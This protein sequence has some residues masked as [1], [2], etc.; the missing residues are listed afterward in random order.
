MHERR[1]M[2]RMRPNIG[3]IVASPSDHDF[4]DD[5]EMEGPTHSTSSSCVLPRWT[6]SVLT[7]L[8]A[9]SLALPIR[10][11]SNFCILA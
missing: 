1:D 10:L 4:V 2:R 9:C 6:E 11:R 3:G 7:S 8:H 5:E